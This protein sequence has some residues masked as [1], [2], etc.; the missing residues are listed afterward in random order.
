MD[1]LNFVALKQ[2]ADL[3]EQLLAESVGVPLDEALSKKV[4]S[5]ITKM[6]ESP[7]AYGRE[8][9]NQEM[10]KH[11]PY[12]RDHPEYDSKNRFLGG[13]LTMPIEQDDAHPDVRNFLHNH[14]YEISDYKNGLATKTIQTGKPAEGIP[15][16]NVTRT[17]KI[18]KALDAHD[19]P[20]EIK[21]AFVNKSRESGSGEERS[22]VIS[23]DAHDVGSMSSCKS[24]S[25]CMDLDRGN[26]SYNSHIKN[27]IQHGTHVAYQVWF[28]KLQ[29]RCS[30]RIFASFSLL[31][32]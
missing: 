8:Y 3:F 11:T 20:E 29:A 17:V 31:T 2:R 15:L 26:T 16:R 28:L 5:A 13:R 10:W 6:K 14:G 30:Y 23:H 27:D 18:G 32:N 22:V 19:A 9:Y 1:F 24:W 4:G 25:S 7:K 12:H 21:K